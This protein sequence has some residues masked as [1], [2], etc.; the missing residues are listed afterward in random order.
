MTGFFTS[1]S[2]A[3]ASRG[4]SDFISNGGHMKL[5]CGAVLGKKDIEIINKA[6]EN[7]KKIIEESFLNE[8]EDLEEGFIKDH[9]KALGWMLA[10]DMLEIK[11]AFLLDNN[12]SYRLD[13]L[14]HQKIGIFKDSDGNMISFSG[15]NNETLSGW[16]SN[17]EEFKV[18]TNWNE[19]RKSL[20]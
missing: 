10:N 19:S 20:F 3:I 9:V 8:L 4:L 1:N 17:I 18:F 16:T 12:N 2:L 13:A 7:P 6:H 5:I 14:F 15:S 11:I